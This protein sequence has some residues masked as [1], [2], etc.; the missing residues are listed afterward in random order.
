MWPDRVSN[1][2][3]LTY[4]SGVLPTALRGPA[5]EGEINWSKQTR[6]KNVQTQTAATR[7]YCKRNRP[8]TYFYP[9]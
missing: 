3:P 2:G 5:R 9:N 8:L 7:N 6:E 1:R 4:E